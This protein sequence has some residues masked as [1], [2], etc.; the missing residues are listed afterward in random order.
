MAIYNCWIAKGT[1]TTKKE[2]V[3]QKHIGIVPGEESLVANPD[4]LL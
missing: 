2:R 3:E 4:L 1:F